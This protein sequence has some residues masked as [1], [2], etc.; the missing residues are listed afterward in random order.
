[1]DYKPTNK[2]LLMQLWMG[3]S[4]ATKSIEGCIQTFEVLLENEK[5]DQKPLDTPRGRDGTL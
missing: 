3:L 4:A 2:E 1:M 5:A